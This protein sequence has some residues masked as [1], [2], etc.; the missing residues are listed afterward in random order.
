[1]G[2]LLANENKLSLADLIPVYPAQD[3]LNYQT[4][5]TSKKEFNE[6]TTGPREELEPGKMFKHQRL[7]QRFMVAMDRGFI[8]HRTGTGKTCSMVAAAEYY[9]MISE[10][11]I[12]TFRS[13]H[14]TE[15][16]IKKVF[17]I[18]RGLSLANDFRDQYFCKCTNMKYVTEELENT[19]IGVQRSARINKELNK[20]YTI[21]TY[22]KFSNDLSK[23][24]D[25][26]IRRD[27]S[28]SIFFADEIHMYTDPEGAIANEETKMSVKEL[29]VIYNNLFR[30][31]HIIQRS[32]V[33]VATATP[34][35]N[36]VEPLKNLMNLILPMDRQIPK[37][38]RITNATDDELIPYLTG[39][40]SY[41][42]ELDTGVDIIEIGESVD[43]D[44][45]ADFVPT[46]K[47]QAEVMSKLQT[48]AYIKATENLTGDEEIVIS[49]NSFHH[50]QRSISSFVFPDGSYGGKF[51]RD[52]T[53]SDDKKGRKTDGIA[54]YVKSPKE[55]IYTP[56]EE[57]KRYL[58]D[59]NNIR[60]SSVKTWAA[61]T[62]AIK[63]PKRKFFIYEREV[64]GSG[65]IVKSLCFE[66]V[67]TAQ[68]PNG[69]S[70]FTGD[71]SAFTSSTQTGIKPICPPDDTSKRKLTIAPKRRY[72]LLTGRT[73]ATNRTHILELFNCY[74][75][76]YGDYI[77]VL[78]GS[79]TTREGMNL[80][81]VTEI[82]ISPEWHETG[83]Y[84]A[85]SRAIRSVSHV[86][87]IKDIAE[88]KNI[89]A[90]DVRIEVYLHRLAAIPDSDQVPVSTD[91]AMY[92]VAEEKDRRIKP[93][94]R[95]LMR[96]AND[97]HIHKKRNIRPDDKPNS[98]QCAYAE[99]D[100]EC[101]SDLPDSTDFNTFDILFLDELISHL[102]S[103][104]VNVFQTSP[105]I[106]QSEL[107]KKYP[108]TEPH[109]INQAVEK[110]VYNKYPLLNNYGYIVFLQTQGNLVFLQ[111]DYPTSNVHYPIS[112]YTT[113]IS[114][115][116]NK[117]LDDFVRTYHHSGALSAENITELDINS[118][119]FTKLIDNVDTNT[120]A[121]IIEFFINDYYVLGRKT[122]TAEYF[123]SNY[124]PFLYSTYDPI[125]DIIRSQDDLQ[126]K[127][128]G[129]GR[130]PILS[131]M[132]PYRFN[133][134][135]EDKSKEKV[136][137]HNLLEI[138]DTQ[139]KYGKA[140]V[141]T[142]PSEKIRIFKPS[143][144][145]GWRKANE[146]ELPV[147]NAIKNKKYNETMESIIGKHLIYGTI[148][149]EG[150][151]RIVDRSKEMSKKD[152]RT[153]STG[154]D[155]GTSSFYLEEMYKLLI[156]LKLK[157]PS[158]IKI[159][160]TSKE[161]M[162]V[163]VRKKLKDPNG[164]YTDEQIK[165]YY[166]WIKSGWKREKIC[167]LIQEYFKNNHLLITP[168]TMSFLA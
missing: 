143:E 164:K 77:Q 46:M 23:K 89:S 92:L 168:D 47:I 135:P 130:K 142:K 70:S 75:N 149:D 50:G 28:N 157:P 12:S 111:Y 39:M 110:M 165:D 144:K 19:K 115:Y 100:Y 103:T 62:R 150:V 117:N 44:E 54:K 52:I 127:S 29:N 57:F 36:D 11:I 147:Y 38:L 15:T 9:R 80:S 18:V 151:F 121:N 24:T 22:R 83:M 72:A 3:D 112:E 14:K 85:I 153:E 30:L 43:L 162:E 125:K 16:P 99:C 163:I 86:N 6:L 114:A 27:Y 145:L 76:R 59:I 98:A 108:T 97:C 61:L 42:R 113:L 109:Y 96:A 146:Y 4:I 58:S 81:D 7:I 1:M 155:C 152:K 154:R 101:V 79:Q 66:Y 55:G 124:G 93:K 31:F 84:Q 167:P 132:K 65:V 64:S 138:R 5:I 141:A 123:F 137:F 131:R 129:K 105:I 118:P 136:Y 104:L 122:K 60:R 74:E 78:I 51:P 53:R 32:K 49:E 13:L 107:H 33:F 102:S 34:M 140:S 91:V 10:S 156:K 63:Y 87:L 133:L 25:D 56:T 128:K 2:I 67:R 45:D 88:E 35:I 21:T 126:V 26:D 166:D 82:F 159:P 148:S 139:T 68:V 90:D 37:S 40:I 119:D 134:Y 95:L 158:D 94:E 8:F 71:S 160:K 73:N 116:N 41:V 48:K 20:W 69:F 161:N 17:I 106:T 120:L